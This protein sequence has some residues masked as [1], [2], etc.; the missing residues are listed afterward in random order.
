MVLL[1]PIRQQVDIKGLQKYKIRGQVGRIDRHA[2]AQKKQGLSLSRHLY[3]SLVVGRWMRSLLSDWSSL[4]VEDSH[5][6]S[7]M[8]S[9]RIKGVILWTP[10]KHTRSAAGNIL[11]KPQLGHN[12]SRQTSVRPILVKNFS[13]PNDCL[14][15]R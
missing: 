4:S 15:R 13:N 10:D 7:F 5:F 6:M 9:F 3:T 14:A 12:L 1:A 11:C 8:E 2:R